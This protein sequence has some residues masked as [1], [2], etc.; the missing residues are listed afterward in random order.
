MKWLKGLTGA[1][2]SDERIEH[3]KN[4]IFKE[5]YWLTMVI[6]LVSIIV[7]FSLHGSEGKV[8]IYTE[9]II[10]LLT[11]AYYLI[12]STQQ[13]IYADEVEVHDRKSK[14]PMTAKNAMIGLAIG[15]GISVFFGVNSAIQYAEGIRQSVL[16]FLMV[17]FVSMMIYVPI[18]IAAMLFLHYLAQKTSRK[19]HNNQDD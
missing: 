1:A 8:L 12:R 13:G 5:A 15:L 16:Y 17:M 4:K 9:L 11:S 19:L 7:K 18:M 2:S 3:A 14:L 6:C 10:L